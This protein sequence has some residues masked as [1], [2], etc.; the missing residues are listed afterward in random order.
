MKGEISLAAIAIVLFSIAILSYI[1]QKYYTDERFMQSIQNYTNQPFTYTLQNSSGDLIF[2]TSRWCMFGKCYDI[3]RNVKIIIT[4]NI[5]QFD[6]KYE[7]YQ[8][9]A[10][11]YANGC[12]P[13]IY[14]NRQLT[15]PQTIALLHHEMLHEW[16]YYNQLGVGHNLRF[17][18]HENI[19]RSKLEL[20]PIDYGTEGYLDIETNCD[21]YSTC[22]G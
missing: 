8:G 18:Y 20:A 3:H 14:V 5:T 15:V 6:S 2:E 22:G 9:Y 16:I 19:V 4:D 12:Q 17:R 10:T 1:S 11:W 7:N 21:K 13:T